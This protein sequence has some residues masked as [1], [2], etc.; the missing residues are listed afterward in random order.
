MATIL[1]IDDNESWREYMRY[2]FVNYTVE[3]A[4]TGEEGISLYARLAQAGKRPSIVLMDIMLG[5][6][7][8]FEAAKRIK[9]ID[10]NANI[11]MMSFYPNFADGMGCFDV[12]LKKE[13]NADTVLDFLKRENI[14]Y[15]PKNVSCKSLIEKVKEIIINAPL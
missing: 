11:L 3:G 7:C 12:M 8:G 4:E 14:D 15:E 1:V 10:A 2:M 6:M 13:L 9:D 5:G